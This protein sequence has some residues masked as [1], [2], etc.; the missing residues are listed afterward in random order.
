MFTDTIDGVR[1]SLKKFHD[2][3]FLKRYGKVFCVFDQN[4]SGNLSLGIE[5]G[6]ERRFVKIA[7]LPTIHYDGNPSD[8]VKVLQHAANLYHELSHPNLIRITD[9]YKQDTLF[10]TVFQWENGECLFDH[11]NFDIYRTHPE[12]L[13]PGKRFLSLPLDKRMET[14]DIMLSFLKLTSE[15]GYVAIDYYD[16]SILYDFDAGVPHICDIDFFE[17]IPYVNTR[18]LMWGDD[19]F[20]AP[21]EYVSGAILDEATNVYRA[22]AMMFYCLGDPVLRDIESWTAPKSLYPIAKKAV[23]PK[24]SDRYRSVTELMEKWNAVKAANP[25]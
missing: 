23:S 16:G 14:L 6:T 25:L 21:E 2:L 11:W 4:I 9:A 18:G 24:K 10:L 20:R 5:N 17:K 3:S 1:F 12:M 13:S 7:G 8:A 15:H 19:K 22:G